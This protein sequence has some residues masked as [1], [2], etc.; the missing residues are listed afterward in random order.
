ML[1]INSASLLGFSSGLKETR[2]SSAQD[3]AHGG[4][5]E[6]T[7]FYQ[8]FRE[9]SPPCHFPNRIGLLKYGGGLSWCL[10]GSNLCVEEMWWKRCGYMQ[11]SDGMMRLGG[12]EMS[13]S[14]P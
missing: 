8:H 11:A 4:G 14:L 3:L 6:K 7:H 13:P 1:K 12:A 5:L 10:K 2:R 9:Y